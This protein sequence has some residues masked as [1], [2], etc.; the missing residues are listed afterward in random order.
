MD[1]KKIKRFINNQYDI[2]KIDFNSYLTKIKN[3]INILEKSSNK[4]YPPEMSKSINSLGEKEY[5]TS[6]YVGTG[7]NIYI[8]WKQY[9]FY[10]KKKEY[11]DKFYT[12]LKT[13]L[14]IAE[15]QNDSTNSFFMGKS[16]IYMFYC[17]YALEIK[18][19]NTFGKYFN[20]LIELRIFSEKKNAE[21]ELLYGTTGYL[22]ALLFLKKYLMSFISDEVN[23]FIGKDISK[24]LDDNIL[25]IFDILIDEIF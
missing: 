4:N 15:N 14:S 2:N 5:D 8:Y 20:K 1:R 25:H 17:I 9:L 19:K 21:V 12:S 3:Q 6:F 7:G 22:Y 10:D 16:G 13:N 11:L 18:D 23:R 24:I